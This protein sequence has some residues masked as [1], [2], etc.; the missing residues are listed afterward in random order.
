MSQFVIGL[1]ILLVGFVVVITSPTSESPKPK[2]GDYRIIESGGEY[3]LQ[4]YPYLMNWQFV[5]G[6]AMTK[7]EAFGRKK[8]IENLNSNPGPNVVPEPEPAA[9]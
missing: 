5:Y 1:L 3:F 2:G 7:E 4:R 6:R 9:K 8:A